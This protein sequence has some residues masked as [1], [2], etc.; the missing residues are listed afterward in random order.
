MFILMTQSLHRLTVVNKYLSI[1]LYDFV[2]QI[3]VI[4]FQIFATSNIFEKL[5]CLLPRNK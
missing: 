2:Q 4:N 1:Y 3:I 5:Q